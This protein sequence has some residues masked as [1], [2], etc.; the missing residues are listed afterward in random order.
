M[1]PNCPPP[2]DGYIPPKPSAAIGSRIQRL[3]MVEVPNTVLR[4]PIA[5]GCDAHSRGPG[6]ERSGLNAPAFFIWLVP[7]ESASF[8]LYALDHESR[9]DHAETGVRRILQMMA[10]RCQRQLG[11]GGAVNIR[12]R[13]KRRLRRRPAIQF[14]RNFLRER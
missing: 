4:G 5:R 9:C 11:R 1:S 2:A 8:N 7:V 12:D 14:P 13:A 6:I 10:Q 3:R